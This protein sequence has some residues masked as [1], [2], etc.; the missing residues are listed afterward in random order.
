VNVVKSNDSAWHLKVQKLSRGI[1]TSEAGHTAS[2]INFQIDQKDS[3][4]LLGRGF[5]IKPQQQFRN[6]QVLVVIEMPVGK[7]IFMASN[8]DEYHWFNIN[9]KWRN[10]GINIDFDDDESRYDGWD[11]DTEYI[12]TDHGLERTNKSS[13]KDTDNEEDGKRNAV[14]DSTRNKKDNPNGDYRYH[15]PKTAPSAAAQVPGSAE[16]SVSRYPETSSAVVLLSSLG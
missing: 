14:P 10:N 7:K 3:L 5:A 12:M 4:L 6:Q 8:L 2:E 1:T 9:R 15:K 16:N 11:S 13:L